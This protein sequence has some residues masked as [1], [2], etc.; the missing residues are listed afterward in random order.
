M[1]RFAAM[2][3]RG[4]SLMGMNQALFTTMAITGFVTPHFQQMGEL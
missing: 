3:S 4:I 2:G 1:E